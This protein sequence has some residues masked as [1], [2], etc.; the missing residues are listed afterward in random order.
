M[1]RAIMVVIML[2][3]VCGLTLELFVELF[4]TGGIPELLIDLHCPWIAGHYNEFIY[5]VGSDYEVFAREQAV[6][7][8]I[9][10]AACTGSL[11]FHAEDYLPYGEAWNTEANRT[12]GSGGIH[13]WSRELTGIRFRYYL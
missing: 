5:Q 11:P 4:Q 3:R 7:N 2:V 10:A 8:D 1:N 9:L 13:M 6:L 12:P